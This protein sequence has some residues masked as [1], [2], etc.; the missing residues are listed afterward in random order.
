L[1]EICGAEDEQHAEE[2]TTAL[3]DTSSSFVPSAQ[4][5]RTS[6]SLVSQRE[7]IDF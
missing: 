4:E 6:G 5:L 2:A 3:A 7:G 1:E